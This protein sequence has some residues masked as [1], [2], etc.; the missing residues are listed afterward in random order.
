M[1]LDPGLGNLGPRVARAA[2][3]ASAAARPHL[4]VVMVIADMS[5]LS[6]ARVT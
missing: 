6:P 3:R 5:G 1:S 2:R 4:L